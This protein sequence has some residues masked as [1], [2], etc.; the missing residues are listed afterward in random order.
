MGSKPKGASPYGALDM[1][2]DVWEW[3]ADW[4]DSVYYYSQSPA[5][6]PPGP[7]SGERRVLRGGS[8]D[9][10]PASV[11][12]ANRLGRHS[13]DVNNYRGFRCAKSSE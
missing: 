3:V 2:G 5:R 10:G 1:A 7:D 8:W 13:G 9:D 6:N 12:S 11:R 4:Y